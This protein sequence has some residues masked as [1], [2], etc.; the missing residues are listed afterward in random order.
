MDSRN[1][2]RAS[3]TIQGVNTLQD[4]C[5]DINIRGVVRYNEPMASHTTFHVGGPADVYLRPADTDDLVD[6]YRFIRSRSLPSFVIGGGANMVV[7]DA[8]IR[9]VVIDMSDINHIR[10]NDSHMVLGAGLPISD[11]AA[12]AAEQGL[13]GLDFLYSMPGSTGGAVW[14][15]ARCYGSSLSDVLVRVDYMDENLSRKTLDPTD[16]VFEYKNTPFQ[17]N[18]WLILEC[19]LVLHREDPAEIRR[20]MQLYYT[21]RES[22]GHFRWPC[23]GSLFKN[24]RDFGAPTG[25]LLDRLGMRGTRVGGA[26]VSPLHANIVINAQNASAADIHELACLMERRTRDELGYELEREV[27]FVGDWEG[28][29]GG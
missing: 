5:R 7:A 29:F 25:Q 2:Y 11:G 24:N 16:Y 14:M 12:A 9:A 15:N 28:T 22:K 26:C 13:A 23:A 3:S 20:R 1:R 17:H 19:E 8:G 27:L 21:D 6:A 4:I 10:F 18:N